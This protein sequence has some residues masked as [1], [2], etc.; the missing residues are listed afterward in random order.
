MLGPT[1]RRSLDRRVL[2]S[3]DHRHDMQRACP[4]KEHRTVSESGRMLHRSLYEDYL[5]RVR[6][7]HET[8]AFEKAMT[9]R[10]GWG[11]RR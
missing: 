6:G 2:I 10:R 1:K 4:L 5:E 11:G 8:P 3:S 9:K 7:H